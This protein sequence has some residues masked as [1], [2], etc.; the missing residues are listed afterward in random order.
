MKRS[1]EREREREAWEEIIQAKRDN[2]EK[3]CG[4]GYLRCDVAWE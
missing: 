1:Q 4:V 2:E 3:V